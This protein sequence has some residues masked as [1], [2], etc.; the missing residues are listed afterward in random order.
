MLK[1]IKGSLKG[2]QGSTG[3]FKNKDAC[4]LFWYLFI[5]PLNNP[6]GVRGGAAAPPRVAGGGGGDAAPPQT[7]RYKT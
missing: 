4:P 3:L 2:F 1:T 5:E 6:G 7:D